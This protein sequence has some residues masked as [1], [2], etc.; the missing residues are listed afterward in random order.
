MEVNS[1]AA[2]TTI[3]VEDIESIDEHSVS[4]GDFMRERVSNLEANLS[5]VK[6]QCDKITD[7]VTNLLNTQKETETKWFKKVDELTEAI[8]RTNDTDRLKKKKVLG[9]KK[10]VPVNLNTPSEQSKDSDGGG[11][12]QPRWKY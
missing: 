10:I 11:I 5:H 6:K 9:K 7:N 3:A 1:E 4:E 2:S 8:F 12:L